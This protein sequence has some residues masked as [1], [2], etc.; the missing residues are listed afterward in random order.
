M[1]RLAAL[2]LLLSLGFLSVVPAAAQ[3]PAPP[4]AYGMPINLEHAVP[5]GQEAEVGAPLSDGVLQRLGGPAKRHRRTRLF[6]RDLDATPLGIVQALEHDEL[7][8]RV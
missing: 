2:A 3:A 8:A 1:T 6:L 7:P 5:D 4:P